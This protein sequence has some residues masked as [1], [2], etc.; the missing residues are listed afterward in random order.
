[1][2][3]AIVVYETPSTRE[4]VADLCS[5][6]SRSLTSHAEGNFE[7]LCSARVHDAAYAEEMLG[8]A[9]DADLIIFAAENEGEFSPEFKDWIERWLSHRSDREGAIAGFFTNRPQGISCACA[10][11]TYLRHVAHRAGLDYLSHIPTCTSKALP[12]SLD[13]Y[14]RR[15]SKV[16]SVLDD[17]LHQPNTPAPPL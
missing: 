11:E 15:A 1:M 3:K 12:D 14:D 17:I 2:E 10:K 8:K 7:W 5:H 13:T 6:S 16:T 9:L 4:Y